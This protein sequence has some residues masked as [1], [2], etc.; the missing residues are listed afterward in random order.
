MFHRNKRPGFTL[1]ELLV[2]IAIIAILI[3]LLIPAVQKVRTAAAVTQCKNNLKQICLAAHNH[4]DQYKRLPAGRNTA[5]YMGPLP[6]MLPFIDQ[7]ALATQLQNAGIQTSP[8]GTGGA[9]WGNGTAVNV[10]NSVFPVFLCPLDSTIASRPY[11]FVYTYTSGTTLYGGIVGS[12]YGASNYIASGGGFGKSTD[13]FWGQWYGPFYDDSRE[14]LHRI[15]DGPSN[16]FLFGE[17]LGDAKASNGGI[18]YAPSW[19]GA[20]Y[21]VGAWGLFQGGQWYTFNSNH[22]GDDVLFGFGDGSVRSLRR[23]SGASTDWYSSNWYSYMNSAG[24]AENGGA[25]LTAISF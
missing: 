6:A 10:A 2:V 7:G 23:F 12:Q 13:P 1:I 18:N 22:P 3:A 14:A 17:W 8:P 5:N 21:M 24:A 19:M 16:T 20:N 25:D 11:R 4:N 15:P 9:W